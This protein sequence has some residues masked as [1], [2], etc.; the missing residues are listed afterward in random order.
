MNPILG[1]GVSFVYRNKDC[2]LQFT[3]EQKALQNIV[4]IS[5]SWQGKSF[6]IYIPIASI[7]DFL[8]PQLSG[9][10]ISQL[11]DEFKDVIFS[12]LEEEIRA[13][14]HSFQTEIETEK[15]EIIPNI[16]EICLHFSITEGQENLIS[17]FVLEK[18]LVTQQ[19]FK[20]IYAHYK[21]DPFLGLALL[22]FPFHAI[23]STTHLSLQE[24]KSLRIGDIILSKLNEN[25]VI[26]T[27]DSVTIFA[28][29]QEQQFLVEKI[30]MDEENQ[31]LPVGIIPEETVQN[32]KEETVAEKVKVASDNEATSSA[33]DSQ[34]SVNNLPVK[35]SFEA[36]RKIFT[37]DELQQIHEGYTFDL[38]Q[39]LDATQVQILAN[40]QCIGQGEW[41]QID[42][43]LG[44][45]VTHL[46]T[47]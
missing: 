19:L 16:S 46:N 13:L 1:K 5:C 2:S 37:V 9:I 17:F 26:W 20:E 21:T 30:I 3:N 6:Q 23:L 43:H 10:D 11:N 7:C 4:A 24:L 39:P 42:E 44:V 33:I 36:G 8:D 34:F 18:D 40:G 15:L 27:Y 28:Y 22:K 35:I 25:K 29:Q 14:F 38:E 47:K 41:V 45:R 31:D 32:E 12:C